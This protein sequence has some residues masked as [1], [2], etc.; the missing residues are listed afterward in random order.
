MPRHGPLSTATIGNEE[1]IQGVRKKNGT[2]WVELLKNIMLIC[3]T[4]QQINNVEY[5]KAYIMSFNPITAKGFFKKTD[6]LLHQFLTLKRDCWWLTQP[7]GKVL[8]NYLPFC[9]KFSSLS[10]TQRVGFSKFWLRGAIA[11]ASNYG[12]LTDIHVQSSQRVNHF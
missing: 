9:S 12:F 3:A 7:H 10:K 11:D 8:T 2:L 4:V 1:A 6:F 5:S